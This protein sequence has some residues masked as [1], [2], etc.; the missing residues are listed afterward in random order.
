M[1]KCCWLPADDAEGD[2]YDGFG[3]IG[4]DQFFSEWK[5]VCGVVPP[6]EGAC[7]VSSFGVR[8][9]HERFDGD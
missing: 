1:M 6:E 5:I 8:R 2:S 4:L 3:L 7:P 9:I